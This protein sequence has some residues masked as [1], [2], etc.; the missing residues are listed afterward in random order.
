M[1]RDGRGVRGVLDGRKG[2]SD[3]S[4]VDDKD[5]LRTEKRHRFG[6][7]V[8]RA[9]TRFSVGVSVIGRQKLLHLWF[10]PQTQQTVR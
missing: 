10:Q 6:S 5:G 1:E 8:M 9:C 7:H 2:G 4:G 3:R